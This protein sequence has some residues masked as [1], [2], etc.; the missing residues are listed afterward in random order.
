MIRVSD[1]KWLSSILIITLTFIILILTDGVAAQHKVKDT[2]L[3]KIHSP[4]KATIMSAIV[5][6]SG[7]IY[8]RKY[9]K[10]PIIYGGAVAIVYFVNFNHRYYRDFRNAYRYRTDNNPSTVD[11][12]VGTYTD[13][14][15]LDLRD[16][17]RRNLEFT[18][19]VGGAIYL[20]NILDAAID[21][22]LWNYNISDDLSLKVTPMLSPSY[23]KNCNFA[24][25][26]T[27][28]F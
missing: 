12:Y 28:K 16:Y 19:I 22:N 26:F 9:W 3:L 25:R 13:Q 23:D 21:A 6:G 1:N 15:L 8:N 5:P 7:Q 17:Y 10:L 2:L 20:L 24:M 14:N 4:D 18:Y 11:N 27:L